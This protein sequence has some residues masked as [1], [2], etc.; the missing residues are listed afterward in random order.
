LGGGEVLPYIWLID[1]QG[2]VRARHG[3]L[4]RESAL[5]RACRKLLSEG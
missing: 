4:A 2:R 5:R 1:R 3:G